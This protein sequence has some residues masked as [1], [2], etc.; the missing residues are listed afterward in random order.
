MTGGSTERLADSLQANGYLPPVD[1]DETRKSGLQNA[2]QHER[3]ERG[4][5]KA[6]GSTK[7]AQYGVQDVQ[8]RQRAA[9]VNRA[10]L[11]TGSGQAKKD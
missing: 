6:L 11:F 9:E 4:T 10:G 8:I 5:T 3:L 7:M 1:Y 2:T